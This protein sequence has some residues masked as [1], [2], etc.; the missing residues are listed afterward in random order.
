MKQKIVYYD[1]ELNDEFSEA[2]IEPVII[3]KDYRFIHNGL[4][5]KIGEGIIFLISIPIKFIY[6]KIKFHIKYVG[7]EA[8]KNC[9]NTGFFI[10]ANHTQPFCDTFIPTN[11]IF[12]KMNALI[13]NPENVSMKGLKILVKMLHAIPIPNRLD[14]MK[15][16]LETIDYY[17]NRK[18]SA[19]TIYPEAHIW[20]Y[21]T[22]IRNF[23]DVSF[24]YP[25]K[26]D[27]PSFC[28]TNTY[29]KY[30]GRED[31]VQIVSYIDGPFYPDKN[32]S[33]DKE[34]QKDLRNRVYEKMCERAKESNIEV[35]KY[36]KRDE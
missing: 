10:Y 6:P 1:D 28:V 23:K 27:V 11:H 5:W 13:V 19:I 14:G 12:P 31:K 29:Q 21:C 15:K 8:L 35:I 34:R 3:D 24:K 17:I 7:K 25:V 2:K 18:K 9:N 4:F 30:K 33:N 32:I 22:W 20:P 16:F 26:F 36:V